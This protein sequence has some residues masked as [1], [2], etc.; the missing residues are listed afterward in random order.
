MWILYVYAAINKRREWSTVLLV[1]LWKQKIQRRGVKN[2]TMQTT[3]ATDITK[4]IQIA[5]L[6]TAQQELARA[7]NLG[8]DDD[9]AIELQAIIAHFPLII[10]RLEQ[11]SAATERTLEQRVQVL[12]DKM[13]LLEPTGY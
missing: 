1:S 11:G 5:H 8:V 3:S 12:E 4:Q 10:A 13:Q 9:T 7:R 2:L 6:L